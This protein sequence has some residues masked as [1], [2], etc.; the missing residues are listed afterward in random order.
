MMVGKVLYVIYF[1]RGVAQTREVK[2]CLLAL[3]CLFRFL[4]HVEKKPKRQ[5][6]IFFPSK[7]L[8]YPVALPARNE[9]CKVIR[10]WMIHNCRSESR[11]SSWKRS[12]SGYRKM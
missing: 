8:D 12:Y 4:E 5:F 10:I 11:N 7:Q 1:A 6:E 2:L 9:A 3:V